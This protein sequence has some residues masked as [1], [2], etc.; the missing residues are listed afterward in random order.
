M[1]PNLHVYFI[2]KFSDNPG[3]HIPQYSPQKYV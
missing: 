3:M 2:A 1:I